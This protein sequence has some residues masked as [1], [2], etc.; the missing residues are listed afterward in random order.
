MNDITV[1]AQNEKELE[2][3]LQ[4]IR[5]YSQDIGMEFRTEKCSMLIIKKTKRTEQTNKENISQRLFRFQSADCSAWL[6]MTSDSMI[7]LLIQKCCVFDPNS[8]SVT[9]CL[10]FYVFYLWREHYT[11]N[12]RLLKMS[13]TVM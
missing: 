3:L 9:N 12:F 2:T 4:T 13:L 5:I 11:S 8:K 1:F 7:N 6:M 10:Y